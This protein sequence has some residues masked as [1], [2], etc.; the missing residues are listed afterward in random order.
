MDVP[1]SHTYILPAESAAV[2]R[3]SARL[4]GGEDVPGLVDD[5]DELESSVDSAGRA[6]LDGGAPAEDG[7]EEAA[8]ISFH[9]RL[10][11]VAAISSAT[12]ALV[13]TRQATPAIVSA[14]LSRWRG[15]LDTA[16]S[17]G[18]R[19]VALDSARRLVSGHA[20][21]RSV[22]FLN[23][24]RAALAVAVAVAIADVTNVQH[25]FWVVLGTISVLRTN[26]AATG[27]TAVRALAGRSSAS[28][29]APG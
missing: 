4:L 11:A 18:P 10:V 2:L 21:L 6:V 20:S 17:S 29:S 19:V 24:A 7:T 8:R 13:A 1:I 22:W 5:I 25:G 15:G 9:A 27:A 12:D 3:K 23:S 16:S 14:E 28:S 26:A